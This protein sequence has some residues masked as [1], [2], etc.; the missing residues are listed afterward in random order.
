M[1]GISIVFGQ[2]DNRDII[3]DSLDSLS[4]VYIGEGEKVKI[5]PLSEMEVQKA[6]EESKQYIDDNVNIPENRSKLIYP[7]EKYSKQYV[8]YQ[9][10]SGNKFV[11]INGFCR[12]NENA[13]DLRKTLRI[14]FDGGNCFFQMK[15]D[16]K[17][18]KCVEFRVNGSA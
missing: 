17:T 1:I 12:A 18:G 6:K 7:L 8:G 14:V 5:I 2:L 10:A 4:I 11:Y 13:E 16:I 9:D 3:V 15:I